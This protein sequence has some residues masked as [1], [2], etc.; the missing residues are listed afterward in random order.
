MA[1]FTPDP[2]RTAKLAADAAF[3]AFALGIIALSQEYPPKVRA[4]P[5]IVSWTLLALV[6]LDLA[7]QT[8]TRLG[9]LIAAL[10]GKDLE[11]AKARVARPN[12]TFG[13]IWVPAYAV[14]VYL[15]GFLPTAALY[16]FVSMAAFGRAGPV[17]AAFWAAALTLV[18][19]AF[20]ELTLG[21]SLF[22]GVLFGARG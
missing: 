16:A 13:L 1:L 9:R 12:P 22:D 3:A 21:F 10:T 2:D 6:A 4:F 18:V 11:S 20:F 19:W 17:R 5:L 14:A 7:S 8:D 15:I